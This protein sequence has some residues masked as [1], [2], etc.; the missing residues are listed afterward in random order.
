ML[1]KQTHKITLQ[2]NFT[3]AI[4]IEKDL[5][6]LKGSQANDKP[7]SSNV[8]IKTHGN[9][10]D[11]DSFDMKGLHRMVKQLSNEIIDLKKNS[12]ES[13]SGRGFF[14]FPDKKHFPQKQHPPPKNINI[15]DY[16]MDN[17]F[18]AHKD[19]HSEKHCPAF[20]NMF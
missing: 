3:E 20:I 10:R 18:W 17:F 2:D 16:A 6:N 13:T 8:P 7:S 5:A 19:N 12:G 11:Q 15:Q 9:R 1:L 4:R 14:R